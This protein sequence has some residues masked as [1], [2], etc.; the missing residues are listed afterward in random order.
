MLRQIVFISIFVLC[1]GLQAGEPA[2]DVTFYYSKKDPHLAGAEKALA[3]AVK[4]MPQLR[5]NRVSID[6]AEGYKQLVTEEKRLEI[7]DPGEMTMVFGP[8]FLTS[9]PRVSFFSGAWRSISSR[10]VLETG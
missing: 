9:K 3:D 8:I 1:A 7:K 6:D 4:E 5:V 10:T 2:I